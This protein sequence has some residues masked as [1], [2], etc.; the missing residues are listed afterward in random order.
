[1]VYVNRREKDEAKKETASKTATH[2]VCLQYK[3]P[4]DFQWCQYCMDNILSPSEGNFLN[5]LFPYLLT[6][7][8]VP[9]AALE[10]SWAA[11]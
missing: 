4:E 10:V 11:S 2:K 5:A 8:R 6:P 1:M 9:L 3:Q 7:S